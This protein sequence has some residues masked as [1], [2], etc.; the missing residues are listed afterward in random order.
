MTDRMT[1]IGIWL[2]EAREARAYG[3]QAPRRPEIPHLEYATAARSLIDRFNAAAAEDGARWALLFDELELAPGPV[4]QMLLRAMRG[5][6]ELLLY[7]VSLA[8]YSEHGM[9][10]RNAMAASVVNDYQ[11]EQLT[12]PRKEDGFR[13]ARALL[14]ARLG[15]AEDELDDDAVLGASPFDTSAEEWIESGT[16]YRLDSPKLQR[17]RRARDDDATFARWL[18]RR[19]VNLDDPSLDP[20]QRAAT[21]RK[22]TSVSLLRA[23]FRTPD[24]NR[25]VARQ[26]RAE[27]SRDSRTV[28]QLYAGASSLYAMVEAN[29][30]WFINLVGPLIEQYVRTGRRVTAAEQARAIARAGRRFRAVLKALPLPPTALSRRPLGVLPV[31]DAIGEYFYRRTVLENFTS[32]PP[33]SFIVDRDTSDDIHFELTV[34]LN[35]GAIIH[36]PEGDDEAEPIADLRGRRFRLSYLLAPGY[37]IAQRLVAP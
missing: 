28:P 32:D 1:S 17:L 2:Q 31:L 7:K 16:A 21:L 19:T 5:A 37:R 22:V 4:I 34:A 33:G 15:V 3:D 11:A 20:N 13:F 18:D 30:R 26:S 10:L 12:Y 8:P 27:R 6:D 25:E 36:M 29:P 23:E 24:A 9:Q 35:A 14:A